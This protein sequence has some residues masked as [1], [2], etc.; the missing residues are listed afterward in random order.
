MPSSD[1][2]FVRA[3]TFRRRTPPSVADMIRHRPTPTRSP[4]GI[5]PVTEGGCTEAGNDMISDTTCSICSIVSLSSNDKGMPLNIAGCLECAANL[6][7]MA[8]SSAFN[9][10]HQGNNLIDDGKGVSLMQTGAASMG[11]HDKGITG[12][13]QCDGLLLGLGCYFATE[14]DSDTITLCGSSST[15]RVD[16]D[17]GFVMDVRHVQRQ[18]RKALVPRL[19]Q[20]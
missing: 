8:G 19:R 20:Q 7:Q 15:G 10:H 1:Q 6:H 18:R 5:P 2:Q 16:D 14:G 11:V 13:K 4:F 12:A 3:V 9:D 17:D